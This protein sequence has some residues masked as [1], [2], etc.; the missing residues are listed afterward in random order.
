MSMSGDPLRLV[1]VH[2][3]GGARLIDA[4]LTAWLEALAEGADRSDHPD[5]AASLRHRAFPVEFAHYGD[6]F[7]DEGSQGDDLDL[8]DQELELLETLMADL[9]EGLTDTRIGGRDECLLD[10]V[11]SQLGRSAVGRQGVLEPLRVLIN[12]AT[13]LLSLSPLRRPGQ[14]ATGR[15]MIR[16]LAQVAR[17]LARGECDQQGTS[18]DMRI[19]SRIESAISQGPAVVVAHSLGSVVAYETL[20][21]L[22]ARA[23]LLMTIGSPLGMRLAVWPHINPQSHTT[24]PNVGRW[25]NVWDT[26]DIVAAR[27]RLDRLF[28]QNTAGV[29]PENVRLRSKRL[30]AHNALA[31]LSSPEVADPIALAMA[32]TTEEP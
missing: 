23:P 5:F 25:V 19:R 2:G 32:P 12:V 22:Q 10:H 14:W 15:L 9:V 17:Y 21:A 16:D 11:Q 31:Y 3:I 28:V 4:E 30:W 24:P 6:L 18:L 29:V 8:T 27:P 20:H 26:D 13:S 1:F 7:D